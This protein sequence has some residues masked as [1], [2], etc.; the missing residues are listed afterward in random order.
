MIKKNARTDCFRQGGECGEEKSE[1]SFKIIKFLTNTSLS[2]L[3][4]INLYCI[5]YTLTFLN[6]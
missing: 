3:K 2:L 5:P 6:E 4:I 1:D